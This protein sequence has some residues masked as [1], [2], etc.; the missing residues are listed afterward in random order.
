M[1][2]EQKRDRNDIFGWP[3]VGFL[4]KNKTFL[5]G[6]RI[7]VFALFLYGVVYGYMYQ[8]EE[9]IFTRYLFWG[10][11]WSFFMVVTLGSMGRIFCGICPHGFIGKYLTKWGLK[12]EMPKWMKN[13][14]IGLMLIV[15]GWWAVYYAAPGFYKSP[16]ATAIFFT[17]LTLL[18]FVIFFVYKD[19]GYCKSICPIGSLTKAYGRVSFM[20]L[21]AYKENCGECKSFDCAKACSYNLKPFTFD[22]KKSMG[23]CSLCMDCADACE[24]ISFKVKKPSYSLFEKFSYDKI[25]VWTFILITAAITMTMSFHHALG[26]LAIADSFPWVRTA[27]FFNG[28]VNFG[29]LDAVGI[30]AFLYATA[31]TLALVYGGMFVAAKV[32]K[33]EFK[34]TFYT[35]GYAFAPLFIIGGLGHL[36]E[37]FFL[38]TYANIANGFIQGFGL[39]VEKVENLATRKDAWTHYFTLFNYIAVIWALLIMGSRVKRFEAGKGAKVLAFF[40]ASALILFYLWLNVYKVYAFAEYG[41]KRSGH[42]GHGTG[43]ESKMFRSIDPKHAVLLQSGEHKADCPN[44]GMSLPMFYKTN[45]AVTLSDGVTRQFCSIHCM[46]DAMEHGII[47]DQKGLVAKIQVIDAMTNRF[48]DAKTAH[49]VV[50]SKKPGTMSM[51]SKYAFKEE[52]SARK[53]AAENGGEVMDFEAAYQKAKEDFGSPVPMKH[54]H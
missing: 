23:D 41:M 22:N 15:I 50:G 20:W 30:F 46:A 26:R 28:F 52:A 2:E 45:H 29:T 49:Y 38:H 32:L 33:A 1:V 3:V 7:A 19:M 8:G 31:V 36:W 6:L 35:L 25:E 5:L 51:V 14:W 16:L 48:I 53:F 24:G 18:A 47:K 37:S 13:P 27:E 40:A 43:G 34:T 44:C 4:F 10:L 12:K 11:F 42:H 17:V 39:D 9:N 21:G 54:P